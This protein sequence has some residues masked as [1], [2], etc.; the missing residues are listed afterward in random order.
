MTMLS[1]ALPGIEEI[2]AAREALAQWLAPTRLVRAPAL[3]AVTGREVWLKLE[4]EQPTGSFKVRGALY[5]LWRA[6]QESPVTQVVASSTG[7]HGA[8]VAY[9]AKT[10][11]IE[12]TIF[13]PERHNEQKRRII[14]ELGARVVTGGRDVAAATD[15]ARAHAAAQRAYFLHDADDPRLP[16]GPAT[17][18]LE[19]AEQNPAVRQLIVPVGD[20]ALLRGVVGAAQIASPAA[21]VVGVQSDGAPAYFLSVEAGTVVET[22]RCDTIADGL[23]TRRPLA[24]NV[25]AVRAAGASIRLVSDEQILNAIAFLLVEEKLVAE[26]AAAAPVALLLHDAGAPVE[27]DIVLVITGC[28]IEKALLRRAICN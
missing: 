28:N 3:S 24:E 4:S 21:S 2:S 6:M 7:N 19:I 12:A 9:A 16:A 27:G 25:A 1:P 18:T 8:A 11:D 20:T 13:L 26:P 17:I 10:L 22:E 23:A 5:A 14:E 15:E